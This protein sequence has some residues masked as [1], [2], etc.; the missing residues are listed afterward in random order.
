MLGKH[1]V[2]TKVQKVKLGEIRYF[3]KLQY[4]TFH[5]EGLHSTQRHLFLE[6]IS[7]L[8]FSTLLTENFSLGLLIHGDFFPPIQFVLVVKG[9]PQKSTQNYLLSSAAA[10]VAE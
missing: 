10:Q 8:I 3:L 2:L 6:F 1:C 9:Q 5:C 7:Y 4:E